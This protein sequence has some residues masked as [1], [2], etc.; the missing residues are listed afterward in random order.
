MLYINNWDF[1]RN[2]DEGLYIFNNYYFPVSIVFFSQQCHL[3]VY[4]LYI[5][6]NFGLSLSP[7]SS[8]FPT[9]CPLNSSSCLHHAATQDPGHGTKFCDASFFFHLICLYYYSWFKISIVLLWKL[10]VST[11]WVVWTQLRQ[12]LV[13]KFLCY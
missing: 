11:S 10:V 9:Y 5:F 3:P 1:N 4:G 7:C 13:L 6:F 12:F 2:L 8:P